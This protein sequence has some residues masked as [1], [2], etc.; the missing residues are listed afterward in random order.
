VW[1]QGVIES[2]P[3]IPARAR[4]TPR[5]KA[6]MVCDI[7]YRDLVGVL[8]HPAWAGLR[9][10]VDHDGSTAFLGLIG[11]VIQRRSAGRIY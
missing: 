6:M 8:R 4:V 11:V 9:V 1:A 7:E 3:G 2:V 10:G 5:A